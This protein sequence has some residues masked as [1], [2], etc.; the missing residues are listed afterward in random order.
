MAVKPEVCGMRAAASAGG[1]IP[2]PPPLGAAAPWSGAPV[3]LPAVHAAARA[4]RR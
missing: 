1:P 2:A 3:S 4:W